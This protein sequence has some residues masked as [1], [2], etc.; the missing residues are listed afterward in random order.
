MEQLLALVTVSMSAYIAS[1][2]FAGKPIYDVLLNRILTKQR[3]AQKLSPQE[4]DEEKHILEKVVCLGAPVC[5]KK[6]CDIE[7]PE[8]SLLVG[9]RRGDSE[10]I[11]APDTEVCPG[12]YLIVLSRTA[13]LSRV[14]SCLQELVGEEGLCKEEER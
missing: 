14:H 2:L 5:H 11:P 13:M 12:D 8:H 10:F 6:I 1:D 9:I 7:W 3:A 4:H